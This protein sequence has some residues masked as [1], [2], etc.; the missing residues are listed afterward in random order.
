MENQLQR[1]QP[2]LDLVRQIARAILPPPLRTMRQFA[3][4]VI[5]LPDGPFAGQR[6]RCE[7]QP[8]SALWFDAVESGHWRRFAT[9][10]PT[11]TGKTLLCAIIPVLYYLFERRE[12]VIFGV[13]TLDVATDKWNVDL[14]PVIKSSGLMR[15]LPNQGLGSRGGKVNLIRFLNGASLR[16]MTGGGGDENRS[17]F[18]APCVVVTEADKMD[19]QGGA[20]REA[21]KITQLE[22][23]TD[24]FG[25]RARI[26]LECTPS[27]EEGRIWQEIT[28]GSD[29]RI[30]IKCPH[31]Q[32]YVTPEREQLVGWENA[33]DLLAAGDQTRLGCPACG[34]TW[35]EA[36]RVKANSA[37]VLAHKGQEVKPDGT[38]TGSLPRTNTLGFRWSCVNNLLAPIRL[39]GE[40]E[41][42]AKRSPDEENA[43][44]G[45]CQFKWARPFIAKDV[46]LRQLDTIAIARRFGSDGRGRV[47]SGCEQVVCGLDVGKRLVHGVA[48]ATDAE[49]TPAVID[50]GRVEVASDEIAEERALLI[51]LRTF[52][53][54]IAARGWESDNG[55][56]TPVLNLIDSGYLTHVVYAFCRESGTAWLPAKGFG[57]EQRRFTYR[58]P[59]AKGPQIAEIGEGYHVARVK[60]DNGPRIKLLEANSDHWKSWVHARLM[61]PHQQTGGMRLFRSDDVNEH[62]TF[63]KHLTAEKLV[64]DFVPGQGRVLKWRAIHRNNH[65]LDA[66]ALCGIAAQ[67]AGERSERRER[68]SST[69]RTWRPARG[70][71]SE[72]IE[73]DDQQSAAAGDEQPRTWWGARKARR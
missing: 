36:D 61:T 62:L 42:A 20:S 68:S 58:A 1:P 30:C 41:W 33:P 32:G 51:A 2:V 55:Q 12:T 23:R 26:F 6:F 9:T 15:F 4:E 39:V 67:R 65:F 46:D 40:L 57:L 72:P 8:F 22:R 60:P 25:E 56:V 54:D 35:D 27:I 69:P 17:A 10:G 44:K 18:T 66:T 13:P 50:Y 29:S 37:I 71:A 16:F 5:V 59:R 70:E 31:C 3:E 43:D 24:A 7:N 38:L 47:P 14:L 11:Q 64:E 52:R 45:L 49:G 28:K 73:A 53:D 34:A 21:D 48:I 63:A 19:E